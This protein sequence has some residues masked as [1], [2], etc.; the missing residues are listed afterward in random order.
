MMKNNFFKKMSFLFSRKSF[1]KK[2][3]V[4]KSLLLL[5]LITFLAGCGYSLGSLLSPHI[6][7]VYV[8]TFKNKTLQENIEI[9]VS[10]EIKQRYNWDGN[11]RVVN[12]KEE[13]DAVLEGEVVDYIRQPARYSEADNKTIDE[14]KLVVAVNLKFI[15]AAKDETL[16]TES[17]FT[18]EAFYV[19]SGTMADTQT[20]VRANSEE[21]AFEFALEDLAQNVVDRTTEGW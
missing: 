5:S 3:V 19:I 2:A 14:Y 8:E 7:T 18:G 13:A 15:D 17:N 20:R 16:W 21:K 11:L 4:G 12:N 6:K 10:D 9:K 1:W